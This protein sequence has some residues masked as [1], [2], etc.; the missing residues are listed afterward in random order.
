M[1]YL[2]IL[3]M[4]LCLGTEWLKPE[5]GEEIVKMVFKTSSVGDLYDVVLDSF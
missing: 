1:R 5:K 2:Q 3:F 4:R